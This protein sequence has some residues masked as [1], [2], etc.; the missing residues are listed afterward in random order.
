MHQREERKVCYVNQA[1]VT[2]TIFLWVDAVSVVNKVNKL[3]MI[4]NKKENHIHQIQYCR[5]LISSPPSSPLWS[6]NKI[7]VKIDTV[8][9]I[10]FRDAQ[11]TP[12]DG[13]KRKTCQIISQI[14]RKRWRE[15]LLLLIDRL[16]YK[17]LFLIFKHDTL[18]RRKVKGSTFIP[19]D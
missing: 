1:D 11:F 3:L 18:Q 7:N 6:L 4:H 13:S 5:L 2:E 17:H 10:H 12:H 19:V 14:Q 16:N 15:V 8:K 9:K